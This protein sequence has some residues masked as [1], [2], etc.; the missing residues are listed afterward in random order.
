MSI[1]IQDLDYLLKT[2]GQQE[3]DLIVPEE[4]SELTKAYSKARRHEL[5]TGSSCR[6][7]VLIKNLVE[8]IADVIICISLISTYFEIPLSSID[9]ML[10]DK[11]QRNLDR[12]K[13]YER[14]AHILRKDQ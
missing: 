9:I 4:L 6:E 12:A 3:T 8:E 11:M 1:R 7:P 2:W 5:Q 14:N 10:E 13:Q